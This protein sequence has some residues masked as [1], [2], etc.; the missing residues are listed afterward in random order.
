M[1]R[2]P[3]EGFRYSAESQFSPSAFCMEVLGLYQARWPASPSVLA[4][5]G[6]KFGGACSGLRI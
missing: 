2:R 5:P 1:S 6:P 4:V 3:C